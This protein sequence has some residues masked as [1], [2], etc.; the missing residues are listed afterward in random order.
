MHDDE[1]AWAACEM[2]LATGDPYYSQK[3]TEWFP[4]P[5]DPATRRWGWWRMWQSY[6]YA[7]RSYAFAARS[8]RLPKEQ[9][10]ANYLAKCEAEMTAAAKDALNWSK[11]NAYGSSFPI[12]TK[13]VSRA[14]WYFSSDYSSDMAAAYQ[15]DPRQEYLDALV[16][17][18]DYEAGCNPVNITYLT[19]VGW[20]RQREIVHQYAQND[21]RILPPTGI[22]LGNIQEG[23]YYVET[24]KGELNALCFPQDWTATGATPFYDRWADAYNVM[25]EFVHLNQ[26]RS[27]MSY[28]LLSSLTP[29]RHQAWKSGTAEIVVP[30]GVVPVG[31]AVTLALN[32]PGLDVS[33]ARVVWEGRDQEPC[34]GPTA[35]FIPKNNG[36][37]WVE[38]EVQWSDGRRV[39]ATNSFYANS[40]TLTWM[41]DALPRGANSAASGGDSWTWVSSPGPQSGKIAHQSAL[42]AGLHSH[43][44]SS[45]TDTLD[46]G[47]GETLFTYV[48]LNPATPPREVMLQW[49]DGNWE[50]RAYWG[51]NLITYGTDGTASRRFMGPLPAAGMWVRLEVPASAVGLENR[52][53]QGMAFT[54][55]D[56]QATWDATGKTSPSQGGGGDDDANTNT[57]RATIVRSANGQFSI[58]WPS[59]TG[60]TYRVAYK[61]ELSQTTWTD[62]GTVAGTGATASFTDTATAGT[63]RRF[64]VVYRV[65]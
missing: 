9:L 8:G 53:L 30:T 15:L 55:Y 41:D 14:G 1:L 50:H 35:A 57:L 10:N 6:G 28:S 20:K 43:H 39:F 54:L 62:L 32:V 64:Y 60:K 65:N 25:T 23:F 63:V 11:D 40:P 38:V 12:P 51:L 34:Y 24:Y 42:A 44:F 58:T 17:N 61:N 7:I 21:R 59:E 16:A 56:G 33:E 19:G 3:L 36:Q 45:A 31:S 37:Q 47:V 52:T 13:N 22:P 2:F 46:I 48:F 27:L 5:N 29:A 49:N 4:D 18:L 26:A